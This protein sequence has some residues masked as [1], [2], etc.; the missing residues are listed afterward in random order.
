MD[1]RRHALNRSGK[2]AHCS[3]FSARPSPLSEQ[4]RH[5]R[6]MAAQRTAVRENAQRISD[7]DIRWCA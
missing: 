5:E 6:A 1:H 7:A 3:H 4:Q 2:F